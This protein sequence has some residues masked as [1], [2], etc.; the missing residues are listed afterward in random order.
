MIHCPYDRPDVIVYHNN[1][2]HNHDDLM[3]KST[4]TRKLSESMIEFVTKL[5]EMQTTKYSSVIKHIDNARKERN[6]F[7]N[8]ENPTKD[9]IAYRLKQYRD[10]EVKPV[11]KLGDLMSWCKEHSETP[12]DPHTPFI[13]DYWRDKNN[14]SELKFRFV[15]S[16]LFLLNM[17]KSVEKVCIDSTYK[18]NWNEFPLTILGTVDRCKKFHPIAFACTTHEKA[19]DY[20]FVFDAVKKKIHEYF[21]KIFGPRTLISDAANAIR[22]AFYRIFPNATMDI[23]CYAHVLRN[24]DKQKFKSK[25]NKRLIKEDISLLQQAPDKKLFSFMAK[26]FCAK[27]RPNEP[28]FIEYFEAQWLGVHCNWFEGAAVYTPSTNNAQESV[29]NVI[30]MKVTLRKRLPMNQFMASM[31]KLISEYSEALSN[32]KTQFAEEP[33]ISSQTWGEGILMQQN[34]FKSFPIKR[35]ASHPDH[36]SFVV[37][38]SKCQNE[39]IEY[40]KTLANKKWASFDEY[41]QHGF[42]QFYTVKIKSSNCWKIESICTCTYFMKEYMCKHIVAVALKES[43]T[44]CPEDYDPMLLSSNKRKRGNYKKVG[45]ALTV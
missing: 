26:M 6:A 13:L 20:A 8:E 32:E 41:I 29:N 24:V 43:I 37:P 11:V 42:Q 34:S 38:S 45:P 30:K 28:K 40:Y 23:M 31:M 12:D 18:L 5:F 22:N 36:R 44:E 33:K 3:G 25:N 2:S 19:D 1:L 4:T 35:M 39:T 14:G 16:T 15:F 21:S 27:W 10:K 7:V 17:F 9:Q